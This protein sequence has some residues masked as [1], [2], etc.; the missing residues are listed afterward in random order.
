[1]ACVNDTLFNIGCGRDGR[2]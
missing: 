2:I 1:M